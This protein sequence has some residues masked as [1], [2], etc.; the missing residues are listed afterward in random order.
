MTDT[1]MAANEQRT[2][3]VYG[4]LIEIRTMDMVKI[5]HLRKLWRLNS[6]SAVCLCLTS[7]W[8]SKLLSMSSPLN[9][10]NQSWSG[11]FCSCNLRINWRTKGTAMDTPLFSTQPH[12]RTHVKKI[13]RWNG[14]V[15]RRAYSKGKSPFV[16]SRFLIRLY[17]QSRSLPVNVLP[18]IIPPPEER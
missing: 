3:F 7:W 1:S 2:K 16:A 17:S 6:G 13:M 9:C 5:G 18:T 8:C 11:S 12:V 10:K 15:R 4:C 14:I